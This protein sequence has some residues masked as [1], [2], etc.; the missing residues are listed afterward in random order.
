MQRYDTT[1]ASTIQRLVDYG[2]GLDISH[3][4]LHTKATFTDSSGDKIIINY[5]SILDKYRD[6]INLHTTRVNFTEAEQMKYRYQPKRLS[7]D[8]Y[9]TPELWSSILQINNIISTAEFTPKS[10]LVFTPDIFDVLNEILILEDTYIKE[11]NAQVY[12]S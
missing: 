12:G 11:N 9:Q 8:L 7:M 2:N 10:L 5:M 3:G 6:L 1:Q 4:K